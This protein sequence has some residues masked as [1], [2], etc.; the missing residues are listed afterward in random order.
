MEELKLS[1]EARKKRNEYMREYR[2]K[3]KDKVAEYNKRHWEKKALED[4]AD[5][6]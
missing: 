1:D 2:N 6:K 4:K 3:N 5:M